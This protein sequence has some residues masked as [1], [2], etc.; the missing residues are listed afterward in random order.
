MEE[1]GKSIVGIFNEEG[2]PHTNEFYEVIASSTG[3][4]NIIRLKSMSSG[5]ERLIHKDRTFSPDTEGGITVKKKKVK[6]KKPLLTFDLSTLDGMGVLFRSSKKSSMEAG[7]D[8]KISIESFCIVSEDG[9]Q[10]KHFNLYNSSLG[11]KG[12]PP[13]FGEDDQVKVELSGNLEAIEKYLIKKGY[14]KG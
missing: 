3:T 2:D 10:W 5:E 8:Q 11:K 1:T 7:G 14:D 9:T 12:K 13:E 6:K 4:K